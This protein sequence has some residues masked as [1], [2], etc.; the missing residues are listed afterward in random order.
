MELKPYCILRMTD[1]GTIYWCED[2]DGK[3]VC[4]QEQSY[5]ARSYSEITDVEPHVL[6]DLQDSPFSGFGIYHDGGK[7]LR[8]GRG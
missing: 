2:V 7:I 5:W 4:R 3:A 8:P 1:R 6:G